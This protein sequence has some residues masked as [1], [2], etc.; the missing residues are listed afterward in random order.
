LSFF[1]ATSSEVF[2]SH[3]AIPAGAICP[4]YLFIKSST[5]NFIARQEVILDSLP[6]FLPSCLRFFLVELNRCYIWKKERGE[7]EGNTMRCDTEVLINIE[8][9]VLTPPVMLFRDDIMLV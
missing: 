2:I 6:E 3:L 9:A 5:H 7:M 8:G 1:P 4:H